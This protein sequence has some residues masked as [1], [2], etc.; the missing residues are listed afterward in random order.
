MHKTD[1][2]KKLAKLNWPNCCQNF[3]SILVRFVVGFHFLKFEFFCFGF[4]GR[5]ECTKLAETKLKHIII[6]YILNI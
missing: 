3:G 1:K 2:P 5:F 4:G 6:Y